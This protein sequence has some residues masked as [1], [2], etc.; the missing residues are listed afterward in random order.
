V[1]STASFSIVPL[2]S[3]QIP[4]HDLETL[5]KA[6]YV[7]G[8][9][10]E[11]SLADS[12]FAA[13]SVRSRGEVLV[14]QDPSGG[15]LGAV[16]AV[17]STSVARRLAG[18]GES[19]MQLLAVRADARGLGIGSALVDAAIESARRFGSSRMILWTQPS[20]TDAQRLYVR[21]GFV[22]VPSLDFSRGA[23]QFQVFAL[24]I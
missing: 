12:L 17:P 1:T 3:T 22:R 7:D 8:G 9:F 14:A 11:P 5:L 13:E 6:V 24:A 4:A 20:M 16:I 21:A 10:T 23:R 19:E 15:L 18:P 2:S